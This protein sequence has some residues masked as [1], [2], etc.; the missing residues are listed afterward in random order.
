LPFDIAFL[1]LS[2]RLR[3]GAGNQPLSF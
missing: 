1:A 2:N 3:F